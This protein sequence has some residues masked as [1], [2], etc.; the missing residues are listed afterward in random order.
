[1]LRKVLF[2]CHLT[3]GLFAGTVVFTMSITGAMLTYEKQM[4]AW[5]DKRAAAIDLPEETTPR[6]SIDSIV[7]RVNLASPASTITTITRRS[8][9]KAPITVALT[10]GSTVLVHPYTGQAIGPAPAGMRRV[11]R[12]A[13]E[14]HR[15]LGG[16]GERRVIGKAITG[17]CNLAFLF[18]VLS[19]LYLWM[20]RRWTSAA[21]AAAG[22]PRWRHP[23]GRARDF[24]WHNALGFWSA[25]PLAIVVGSATVISYP[26]ASDLAYRIV[27]EEPP[28]RPSG[29]RPGDAGSRGAAPGGVQQ[30]SAAAPSAPAPIADLDAHWQSAE[31][32]AAGWQ[33]VALRM[34]PG[35]KGPLTFTIDR[36]YG[37]QPQLRGTLTID[38]QTGRTTWQTFADQSLGRRFR[39]A[40]RFAHTGE[41]WGLAG[42]TVAGVVSVA[43]CVLVWTGFALA[44][45]RFSAW[46]RRGSSEN[47]LDTAA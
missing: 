18:L 28:A 4:L 29:Q 36:G 33:T 7:E 31:Q 32:Q 34:P 44:W 30:H 24:N 22:I 45:R 35:G 27:G 10:G 40:L 17:A 2:W 12:T 15:Y 37:G 23:T 11:F 43:G 39:S 19:G 16:T 8:D 5:A 25:V 47:R 6:A 9:P 3:A 14:W 38:A 42:Q 13:T 41:Y 20:P 46:R 21:V 1:M 26:W